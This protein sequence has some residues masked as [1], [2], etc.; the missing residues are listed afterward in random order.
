[1][2]SFCLCAERHMFFRKLMLPSQLSLCYCIRWQRHTSSIIIR[3][4]HTGQ[5]LV[6]RFRLEFIFINHNMCVSDSKYFQFLNGF[7][8][9][10][11][12]FIKNGANV[13]RLLLELSRPYKV[14]FILKNHSQ[15]MTFFKFSCSFCPPS[16]VG[17]NWQ[18]D[19]KSWEHL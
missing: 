16:L 8:K 14:G 9:L 18:N 1:M 4:F 11:E 17:L 15:P 13:S 2:L 7:K 10:H 6:C 5:K 12:L 19:E 3:V